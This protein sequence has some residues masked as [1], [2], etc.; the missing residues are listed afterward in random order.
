MLQWYNHE[1]EES[2]RSLRKK[3]KEVEEEIRR[4]EKVRMEL[5][6]EVSNL[7]RRFEDASA[8]VVTHTRLKDEVDKLI[9][10]TENAYGKILESSRTLWHDL[11]VHNQR[12]ASEQPRKRQCIANVNTL[13]WQSGPI[14]RDLF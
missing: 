2:L 6:K 3:R 14:A 8:Q 12:L 10:H 5:E 1:L 13:L 11:R 7:T 4:E 9:M